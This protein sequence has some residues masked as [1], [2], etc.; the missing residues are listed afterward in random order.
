[1][2]AEKHA[3]YNLHSIVASKIW[4]YMTNYTCAGNQSQWSIMTQRSSIKECGKWLM[5][6]LGGKKIPQSIYVNLTRTIKPKQTWISLNQGT[7]ALDHRISNAATHAEACIKTAHVCPWKKS[8]RLC[9]DFVWSHVVLS[10]V[11]EFDGWNWCLSWLFG[12]LDENPMLRP[13][14]KRI[15]HWGANMNNFQKQ[16]LCWRN[17]Q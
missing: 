10:K 1:M 14:V 7:N 11:S 12:I 6:L 4:K 8:A 13:G 15:S 9:R 17:L 2:P 5:T 16:L 3:V